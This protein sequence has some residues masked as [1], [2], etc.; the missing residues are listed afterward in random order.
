MHNK[1][2][3][4]NGANAPRQTSTFGTRNSAV[5]INHY[6][7]D[8]IAQRYIKNVALIDETPARQYGRGRVQV[9]RPRPAFPQVHLRR[10]R[11]K[12]RYAAVHTSHTI[13]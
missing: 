2:V 3:L 5:A 1:A 4:V 6:I 10:F 12:A 8:T 13:C 11:G 7:P 9:R